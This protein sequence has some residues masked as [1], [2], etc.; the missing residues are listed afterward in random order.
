ML[1]EPHM[2]LQFEFHCQKL[3]KT[4]PPIPA[5]Q[6]RLWQSAT[7]FVLALLHSHPFHRYSFATHPDAKTPVQPRR[8]QTLFVK[9]N[10]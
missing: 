2:G 1:L 5:C 9:R 8:L 4:V 3:N 6:G 7:S 10:V